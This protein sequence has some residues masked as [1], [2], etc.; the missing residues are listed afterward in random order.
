ML[1]FLDRV[2]EKVRRWYRK[3][4]FREKISCSHND[5]SIIG[6][7]TVINRNIKIGHNVSIYPDVMFFGDGD[8]IIG[9]N[10]AI[11]NG[12]IIYSSKLGGITIGNN[13]QIAAQC[14]IIDCDHGIQRDKLICNQPT[15]VSSVTIG[16]DVWIGAGCKVL[17]G[18]LIHDGAV[19]GAAGLVK[20]EIPEQVIAV[21][22]P[23]K[24]IRER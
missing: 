23:A 17:R 21:G 11:G 20:G 22:S 14:Y 12:T 19:I 7:I 6:D 3:R 5:F 1:L 13:T 9:D 16:E 10:V 4:V 15:V 18:S 8:I 2:K 24:V